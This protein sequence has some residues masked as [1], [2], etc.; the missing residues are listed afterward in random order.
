[1][2]IKRT[3]APTMR[4]ALQLVKQE[5]GPDAVI[6]GNNKV[7]GGVEILSA[8]DFDEVAI[9][10]IAAAA[11]A[12]RREPETAAAPVASSAVANTDVA[13]DTWVGSIMN[14]GRK[15][16]IL[17]PVSG[18]SVTTPVT[19]IK[20]KPALSASDP[21]VRAAVAKSRNKPRQAGAGASKD[22]RL[23]KVE[24]QKTCCRAARIRPGDR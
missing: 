4:D 21:V 2:R 23:K 22:T 19:R 7:P 9:A 14:D 10:K 13:S 5:Q 16:P 11:P 17:G 6:M 8:I 1:M 3:F 18:E 15:E 24:Y 20:P 12:P